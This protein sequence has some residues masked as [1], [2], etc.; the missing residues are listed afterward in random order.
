MIDLTAKTLPTQPTPSTTYSG[1]VESAEK[2]AALSKAGEE[3]TGAET[4]SSVLELGKNINTDTLNG[5]QKEFQR[6]FPE[7]KDTAFEVDIDPETKKSVFRLVDRETKE[8]LQ[9]FPPEELLS[10]ARHIMELL[11][12][13]I[14][15]LKV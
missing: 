14:V 5:L 8:V 13:K 10:F 7:R 2:L 12:G 1:K 6:F 9:Q 4:S 11:D 3:G 15:D